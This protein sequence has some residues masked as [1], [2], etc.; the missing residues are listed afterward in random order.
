MHLLEQQPSFSCAV[1]LVPL[2]QRLKLRFAV[3]RLSRRRH[4]D[5]SLRADACEYL[6][7]RGFGRIMRERRGRAKPDGAV[8]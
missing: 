3:A 2:F 6:G 8:R 7:G 4:A 1:L 5:R